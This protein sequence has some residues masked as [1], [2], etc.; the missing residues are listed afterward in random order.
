MVNNIASTITFILIP[1]HIYFFNKMYACVAFCLFSNIEMDLS[2]IAPSGNNHV[3]VYAS[4]K[5]SP[6]GHWDKYKSVLTVLS[7][8]YQQFILNQQILWQ[9][10]PHRRS[11]Q[12]LLTDGI[13]QNIILCPWHWLFQMKSSNK[14]IC[15]HSRCLRCLY[16]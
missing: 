3:T 5:T 16:D 11:C 14:Q 12:T 4:I 1:N 9:F 10:S 8:K 15:L 7:I 13:S 6:S 2:D